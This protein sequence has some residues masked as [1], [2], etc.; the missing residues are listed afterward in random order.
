MSIGEALA[1]A[2]RRAG[3]TVTQVSQ[4]SRIHETLIT[5]IEGDD[6]SAC[7][8]DFYARGHIRAI[9]KVVGA[10]PVPLIQEYDVR[11]RE[12][13][14]VSAVS[15]EELLATSAQTAHR[16]PGRRVSG[17]AVLGLALVMVLGAG[18][19]RL[20]SGSPAAAVPPVAAQRADIDPHLGP[21]AASQNSRP[22]IRPS[23]PPAVPAHTY[24]RHPRHGTRSWQRQSPTRR[25]DDR[26]SP[27]GRPEHQHPP[28]KPA[29]KH[30]PGHEHGPGRAHEHR[31]PG[32]G[33]TR[34]DHSRR[35]LQH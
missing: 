15:L 31:P 9:A 16:Q 18:G 6:Y 25:H 27:R 4:R 21:A 17:A 22:A 24:I 2:R 5:A 29:P 1:A 3:L 12:P 14:A 10:D 28:G 8:G 20:L 33:H 34:P 7:G 26:R 19:Y 30:W 11:H 13:A 23:R 35:H 32:H